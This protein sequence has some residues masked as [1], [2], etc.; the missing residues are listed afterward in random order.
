M[1]ACLLRR[2]GELVS[3][4]AILAEVWGN[5]QV[6]PDLVRERIFD[7]RAALGDD[8]QRP[9]LSRPFGGAASA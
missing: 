3:R 7:L 9:S 1:L 2:K 5:L 6:S 8:V 4:E